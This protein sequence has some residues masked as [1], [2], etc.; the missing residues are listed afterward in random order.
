MVWPGRSA[1]AEPEAGASA[2]TV[3]R[4]RALEFPRDHGAHLDARTE[5]WYATGWA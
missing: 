1:A 3:R 2:D 4:G 5:W